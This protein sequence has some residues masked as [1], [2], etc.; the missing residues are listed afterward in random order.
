[1]GDNMKDIGKLIK[2]KRL[3]KKLTLQQVGDLVGVGAST[4]R[5]WEEG[6][7]SNMGRDKIYNLCKAIDI[8]PLLLISLDPVKVDYNKFYDIHN[9]YEINESGYTPTTHSSTNQTLTTYTHLMK[10]SENNL[11]DFINESNSKSI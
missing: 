5:K 1:M 2:D 8:S 11:I 10:Q 3:E 7:I 9:V 4:V 6:M